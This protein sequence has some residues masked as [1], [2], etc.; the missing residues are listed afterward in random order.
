MSKRVEVNCEELRDSAQKLLNKAS[1]GRKLTLKVADCTPDEDWIII[2]VAP[3]RGTIRA[4]DFVEIL[5]A[6]EEEL[7]GQG[8]D[9]VRVLPAF[10]GD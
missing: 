8:Y 7:Q 10:P 1:R 2:M 9:Q 3:T 4:Y 5:T 6:V